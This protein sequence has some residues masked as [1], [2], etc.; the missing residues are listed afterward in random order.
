MSRKE[1]V[2]QISALHKKRLEKKLVLEYLSL[3]APLSVSLFLL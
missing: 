3:W 2:A 1:K